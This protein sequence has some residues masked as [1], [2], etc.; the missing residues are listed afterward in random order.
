VVKR[1][2]EDMGVEV[3]ATAGT[4][5]ARSFAVRLA[6]RGNQMERGTF[7]ELE[8]DV[9]LIPYPNH[10]EMYGNMLAGQIAQVVL[11]LDPQDREQAGW[12]AE[13]ETAFR[14]SRVPF[15]LSTLWPGDRHHAAQIARSLRT[16]P[17][18]LAVV[19]PFT[20]P[21]ERAEVAQAFLAA[22][23]ETTG[24]PVRL[25]APFTKEAPDAAG[26]PSALPDR[27]AAGPDRTR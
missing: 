18:P 8:K 23:G 7:Q 17:R 27:P 24:R 25:A 19:V 21:R 22:Y 2:L 9:W 1:M 20:P 3:A 10:H 14:A 5:A 26:A 4:P 11:L 13:A 12:I 6:E 16:L 15:T